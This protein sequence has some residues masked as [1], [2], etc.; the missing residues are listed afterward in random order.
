[1]TVPNI[2]LI[3]GTSIPQLGF[4]VFQVP[5]EETADTVTKALEAGYRHIDTAQMYGT[6]QEVG[7][8]IAAVRH[9]ARRALRH[10]QAQQRL[11]P[12]RRRPP[13]VRRVAGEARPRPDRP[14]PHPLAAAHAVRRR[15]RVDVEDPRASSWPTAGPASIGVSNFQ[16][17]H[18]DRIVAE[19]GV[20]PAVNQIE[21]HPFF[22]NEA[23]RAANAEHG[24]VTE[25]W[26]P[27][28]QGAVV[29]DDD[30][31]QDRRRARPDPVPGGA[32]LAHRSAAT[33]S[34]RSRCSVERMQRELRDLRLR[35]LT[36]DEVDRDQRAR[37]GRVRPD[38]PEPGQ[39]RLHPASSSDAPRRR[40]CRPHCSRRAG[41]EPAPGAVAARGRVESRRAA[42]ARCP[43]VRGSA[44]DQLEAGVG[45]PDPS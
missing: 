28:A 5:P 20:V 40:A 43:G 31:R 11:P 19:T 17:D 9:P 22:A 2:E 39:V 35:A 16:P 10:H 29:D 42:G 14:V 6:R 34:S 3:N 45:E 13:R 15:L 1:M 25:A 36:D 30:H 4:G 18:L 24:V 7:E 27:I 21:V 26:S 32:A 37:P 41:V 12:A 38:R 44:V 8:A 23:A 33:S